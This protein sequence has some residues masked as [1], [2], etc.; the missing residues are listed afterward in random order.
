[1]K[2][3]L[4]AVVVLSIGLCLAVQA[5][6]KFTSTW[7]A[8]GASGLSFAGKKI[9]A[10]VL[11][12]DQ[13]LQVAGEE[14]LVR[15]LGSRGVQGVAA[16]RMIP[17]EELKDAEKARPWFERAKVEG[18]V[19]MRPVSSD[20]V[21]TWEPSI[22][23][24]PYYGSFWSYWGYGW[25][26]VYDPGRVREDHVV[27]VETLIFS[28]PKDLLLWAGASETTNPKD[29]SRFV[30]DVVDAAAKEMRKAGLVRQGSQ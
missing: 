13:S 8:P 28:V 9:A 19:A 12:D 25:G 24:Q 27:V 21:R 29:L 6:T 4:L 30:H 1:M 16:Y 11:T 17:R 22:W 5:A 23:A 7:K 15:E 20:R 26:T 2:R 10:V 3:R 14:A 18:V